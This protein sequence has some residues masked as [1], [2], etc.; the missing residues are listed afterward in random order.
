MSP[1]PEATQDAMPKP[2][3][4]P[5]AGDTQ[6][7][8]GSHDTQASAATTSA[9]GQGRGDIVQPRLGPVGWLRWVWRQLTS[10]R[11]ALLLLLLLAVAAIPGSTFPQR[12]LDA[13]RT[14]DWIDRHPT[15]GPILDKLGF[16]EVYAA[17]WFAAVYLLLLVSLVGCVLPR[18]KK[19]WRE[20]RSAPPRTPRRLE[21]L[22]SHA[23]L[24]VDTSAQEVLET[25]RAALKRRRYRVHAHDATTLSAEKGHLKE[26]GNLF[27]H[28]GLVGVIIG[29]AVG[30]L[31]GFKGD[32][33]VPTGGT[34]ANALINYDTFQPGPQV[35]PA[36]LKPFT[37]RLDSFD[38]RFETQVQSKGQL[39]MPRDF[40]AHVTF[41]PEPG[42]APQQR[43]VRV[44]GPLETGGGTVYLL[45]NGYAPRVTVRGPTGEVIY[46][47]ATPFLARDNNYTSV[48]AIKAPG[49]GAQDLGFSGFFNPTSVID[50]QGPHSIFPQPVDPELVLTA[51][52]GSIFPKDGGPQSVYT[53][54]TSEMTQ[55]EEDGQPALIRIKPGQTAQLPGGKGSI[56]FDGIE[57]FAGLSIR[58]DPGKT[59]TL[60]CS[61][62]SL[63]GL[64]ASLV[65]RRRRVFVRVAPAG[66]SG[67]T[68]SGPARSV[69][70]VGGLTKD[71]DGHDE[72]M[73][74]ELDALLAALPGDGT[75][76]TKDPA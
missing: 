53:L 1:R 16:F 45:G 34:F 37:L 13:T 48:G 76:E 55:L 47:A 8:Q 7:D 70:Q 65:V 73:G 51:F 2:P 4:A 6:A 58:A 63:A 9:A 68:G 24:E 57:R 31:W 29:V 50:E 32:V 71:D 11:T 26:T 28:I 52:E 40:T 3:D 38:A 75:T 35:D 12:S 69:V 33:I 25:A 15:A 67:D 41:T 72:S 23:T 43:V 19:H 30:Q 10:M 46:S 54:D 14:A 27:F 56:T 59:F 60:V 39:G 17:P 36:E 20:V 66:A 44:N 49:A 62:L 61:L 18:S 64:I 5:D 42:A 22:P 21:R 74:E